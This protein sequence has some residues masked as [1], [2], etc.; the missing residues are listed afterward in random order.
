MNM[1]KILSK[2]CCQALEPKRALSEMLRF[3]W[4]RWVLKDDNVS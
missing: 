1:V 3:G 4:E 2:V